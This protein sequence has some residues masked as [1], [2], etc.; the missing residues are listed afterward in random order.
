MLSVNHGDGDVCPESPITSFFYQLS[1]HHHHHPHSFLNCLVCIYFIG[2]CWGD[3]LFCLSLIHC[4]SWKTDHKRGARGHVGEW[5]SIH[6]HLWRKPSAFT[7]CCHLAVEKTHVTL[8]SGRKVFF[9]FFFNEAT[10]LL[11][12]YLRFSYHASGPE[13]DRVA[14]PGHHP[15]GV[16]H[17][18]TPHHVHGHGHAGGDPGPLSMHTNCL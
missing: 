11:P 9:L 4:F 13:W 7:C 16:K 12:D 8:S 5:E 17:P 14:A 15:P 10:F 18:R 1:Q 3:A 6:F 2:W